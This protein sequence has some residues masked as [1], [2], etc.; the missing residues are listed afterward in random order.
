METRS[1][2]SLQK[3][4]ACVIGI[5]VFWGIFNNEVVATNL[6]KIMSM[7]AGAA[8]VIDSIDNMSLEEVTQLAASDDEKEAE[9]AVMDDTFEDTVSEEEQEALSNVQI[10]TVE[11]SEEIAEEV[12]RKVSLYDILGEENYHS[13]THVSY[14]TESPQQKRL[15]TEKHTMLFNVCVIPHGNLHEEMKTQRHHQT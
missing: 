5:I 1:I 15:T 14:L 6:T 3:L 12:N 10:V 11:N 13:F 7:N 8:K 9:A 2:K 4:V